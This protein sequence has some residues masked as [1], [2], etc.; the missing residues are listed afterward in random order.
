MLHL[1]YFV[2][3]A[4][5]LSF[6]RAAARLHMA[7]SPLSRRI[8]DLEGDLGT[9]LFVRGHHRI[10]LTAAGE[11]LLPRAREILDRFDELPHLVRDSTSHLTRTAVLGIAPDVSRELHTEIMRAI[12]ADHPDITVR[13][14]PASTGPL[15]QSLQAG[16]LDLALVHGL[17][18]SWELPSGWRRASSV[19]ALVRRHRA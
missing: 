14:Q 19:I 5:E 12:T 1:R 2:A 10:Q 13:L 3:V 17:S 4:D 15:V 7:T 6:T 11:A 8:K 18:L 16:Q 9:P